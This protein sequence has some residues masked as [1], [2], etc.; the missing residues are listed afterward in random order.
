MLSISRRIAHQILLDVEEGAYA[1]DLLLDRTAS[2]A[3]RDAGLTSELVFGCLRRQ[4]QLDHLIQRWAR[5][6]S[7]SLDAPV[8]AALRLG[9]YQLHF[10]DRIPRHAA[11]SESVELVKIGRKAS[12]AGFV[13]AVLRKIT[14][15]PEEW[16]SRAV[17]LSQPDWLVARWDSQ[18][19]KDAT[20]A[21][22][23]EFLHAPE[24]YLRVPAGSVVPAELETA[25]TD[26]PGC[27][28]LI[29]G[30]HGPFRIQD[31]SS[32]SI[33]PLLELQEGHT[34]LDLCAA[35]GNKTAQA[36]ETPI[37]AVACDVHF[38]RLRQLRTLGC[39]LVQLDGGQTLPFR[40]QFD[41]IL[42]DAP[43]SGTGTIGR[44][45]E[46]RWRIQ[47][48]DLDAFAA[49]QRQLLRQALTALKPG[50]RLVYSTCSL[51]TEENEKVVAAV[52]GEWGRLPA[53]EQRR[54]PGRDPGDGFY[55]AV[56]TS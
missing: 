46:I 56:I 14:R 3:S 13:N 51:E 8:R 39:P 25:A 23:D 54:M 33:V 38:G 10:L 5:R 12:A 1:S 50:G 55:A 36:L 22:G 15:E 41:R 34:Y 9:A 44:N 7:T 45:P 27:L 21:I 29:S 48:N 20:N 30:G 11:V 31:I 37:R 47:P 17:A 16:P 24:T 4:R 52:L 40:T 2:L 32:Q 18:F 43:C 26:V 35:P 6:P 42:L 49:R 19:G 28:R 53:A